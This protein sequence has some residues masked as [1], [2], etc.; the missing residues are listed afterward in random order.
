LE[1]NRTVSL[2]QIAGLSEWFCNKKYRAVVPE[3]VAAHEV[4][5]LGYLLGIIL[6]LEVSN[7]SSEFFF[8]PL[9]VSLSC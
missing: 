9:L 8:A 2:P 6:R 1:R 4:F 5:F 7:F 3:Y